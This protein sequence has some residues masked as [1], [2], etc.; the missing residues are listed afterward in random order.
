M[1]ETVNIKEIKQKM[2]DQ[3]KNTGWDNL[4]KGFIL[5]SEMDNILEFLL[6]EAR[7]G[8]R[9]TPTIKDVFRCFIDT[10]LERTKVILIG[11]DPYP[12]PEV[13]N[14]RAFCCAKTGYL[15]KS[16]EYMFKEI[17]DTVYDGEVDIS[18]MDVNLQRWTN[19]GVLLL[20]SAL[21]TTINKP[22][23]HS[24]LWKPFMVYLFDMLSWQDQDIIYCFLGKTAQEYQSL[25]KTNQY[26]ILASHPASAAYG[27][28]ETWDSGNMFVRINDYLD[29]LGKDSITW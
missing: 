1:L 11:Q 21:T 2:Y 13:A 8:K 23:R 20:N 29:K 25:I 9:F 15:Q 24:V 26:K 27:N 18:D 6:T 28:L 16:L 22:G 10:P 14:G 12:Q 17:N 4:L 19:Q 7:E 5:S 3:L